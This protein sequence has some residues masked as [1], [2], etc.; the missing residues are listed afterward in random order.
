MAVS[1]EQVATTCD[2]HCVLLFLF[3]SMFFSSTEMKQ[4]LVF[5]KIKIRTKFLTKLG[6]LAERILD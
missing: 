4:G 1:E 2:N 6:I 3:L 5:L